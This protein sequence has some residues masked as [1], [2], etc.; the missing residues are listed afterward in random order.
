MRQRWGNMRIRRL[1]TPPKR[2]AFGD[3][4]RLE[5]AVYLDGMKAEDVVV[6]LALVRHTHLESQ[7]QSAHYRFEP[8]GTTTDQGEHRFALALTPEMCGKLEYRM[9]VYPHHELLTHRLEMGMMLWL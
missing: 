3:G 6:E 7:R 4:I 8:D 2:I 5:V 1:D 9:R